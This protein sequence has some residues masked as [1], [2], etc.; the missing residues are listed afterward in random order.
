MGGQSYS[1]RLPVFAPYFGAPVLE[2]SYVVQPMQVVQ[3][4]F[5]VLKIMRVLIAAY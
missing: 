5:W 2:F 4:P 1:N 3:E